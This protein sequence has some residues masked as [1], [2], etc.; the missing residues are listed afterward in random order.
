M[1]H[2]QRRGAGSAFRITLPRGLS[3]RI[4]SPPPGTPV[5]LEALLRE[6]QSI[7]GIQES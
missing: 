1:F 6:K 7:E 4:S 5:A 2:A 3:R